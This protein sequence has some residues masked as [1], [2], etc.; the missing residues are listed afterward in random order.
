MEEYVKKLQIY[1]NKVLVEFCAK[2]IL[3][4]KALVNN[5]LMMF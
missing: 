5:G 2:W 3:L 4:F 1:E